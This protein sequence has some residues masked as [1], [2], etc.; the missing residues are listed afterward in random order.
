MDFYDKFLN[1][2][3]D[4]DKKPS[5]VV[6]E[7][8]MNR[9]AVTNW[10][11]RQTAPTPANMKKIADYFGVPV[12]YFDDDPEEDKRLYALIDTHEKRLLELY[13]ALDVVEQAKLLVYASELKTN[14]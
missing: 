5:N 14:K 11:Q 8:G 12:S 4:A 9:S 2:C 1:L 7:L 10:K 3:N 6:E 13:R